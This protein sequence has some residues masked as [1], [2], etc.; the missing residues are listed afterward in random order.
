MALVKIPSNMIEL[1]NPAYDEQIFALSVKANMGWSESHIEWAYNFFEVWSEYL[2]IQIAMFLV[3]KW[4][5]IE[6]F[7]V[8]C[9]EWTPG[10]PEGEYITREVWS[11]VYVT[12]DDKKMS[13]LVPLFWKCIWDVELQALFDQ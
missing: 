11:D 12:I 4:G 13:E 6:E 9:V 3:S 1:W 8:H 7:D 10:I 2:P 5:D